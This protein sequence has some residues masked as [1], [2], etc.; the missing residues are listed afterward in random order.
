MESAKGKT[1]DDSSG[2]SGMN[3]E[4]RAHKYDRPSLSPKEFLLAVM[5][6]PTVPLEQ[7]IGAAAK[8]MP[9]LDAFDFPACETR[10]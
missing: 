2:R 8:V 5:R 6:D 7:R 1:G 10:G 4:L 9:L 3:L